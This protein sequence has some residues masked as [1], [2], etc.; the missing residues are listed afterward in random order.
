MT[1]THSKSR[2]KAELAFAHTQTQFFARNKALDEQQALVQSRDEKTA[3]L[4]D[5][6]LAREAEAR[7][8]ATTALMAKR[9]ST[10]L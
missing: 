5:A 4:R 9:A 10:A 2:Q 8:S 6:R 3:R 7:S 1:Q